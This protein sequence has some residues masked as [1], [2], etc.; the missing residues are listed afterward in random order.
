MC[1]YLLLHIDPKSAVRNFL[2]CKGFAKYLEFYFLHV[3][4][5]MWIKCNL[6]LFAFQTVNFY[7]LFHF[8][9]M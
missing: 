6:C 3:L 4:K 5:I 7:Q 8:W 9:F 2:L 1:I